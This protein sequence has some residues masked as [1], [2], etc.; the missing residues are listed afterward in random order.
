MATKAIGAAFPSRPAGA[1]KN[2]E[3]ELRDEVGE[4]MENAC[5]EL[6]S[7]DYE[8]GD[9]GGEIKLI[10]SSGQLSPLPLLLR[11]GAHLHD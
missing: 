9:G 10:V 6:A 8:E 1:W 7:P 3:E 4:L 5:D 11:N 2:L